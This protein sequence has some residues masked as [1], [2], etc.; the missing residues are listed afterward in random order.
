MQAIRQ[1]EI[2]NAVFTA[3]RDS[4]LGTVL[5]QWVQAIAG[6]AGKN[7]CQGVFNHVMFLNLEINL[8]KL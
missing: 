8:D 5:G 3:E 7:N 2:N 6:A 4:R 1:G